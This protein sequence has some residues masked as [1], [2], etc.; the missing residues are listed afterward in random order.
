MK[1]I[2]WLIAVIAI[3]A[4][5]HAALLYFGPSLIMARVLG[6]MTERAGYN[7]MVHPPRPNAANNTIV[8]SS[9]DLLYSACAY[10][11]SAGP[12][13][14][15]AEVP[16]DTYWS[17]SFYDLNTNNYR[18]INDGQATAGAVLIV[19]RR[20]GE[21]GLPPAGAEVITSPTERGVIL[22]RTLINDETRLAGI[23]AVRRTAKCTSF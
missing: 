10:D 13:R 4:I 12:V 2:R 16:P 17:M 9:P 7:A 21:N 23:D 6:R 19:L 5:T 1:I 18:V 20:D 3:A 11:L 15:S 14:I 22:I 8:R